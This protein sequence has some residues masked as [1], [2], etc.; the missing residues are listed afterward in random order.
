MVDNIQYVPLKEIISR[1][2][3]HPLLQDLDLE[4]A[5]QYGFNTGEDASS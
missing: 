1:V 4:A 5:I 3:R 2:T